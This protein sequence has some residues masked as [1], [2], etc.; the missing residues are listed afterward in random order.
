MQCT[1]LV[2]L[3]TSELDVDK[4]NFDSAT[5]GKRRLDDPINTPEVKVTT[6]PCATAR[7]NGATK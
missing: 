7:D 2:H 3:F 4:S 1:M 6:Q 5:S